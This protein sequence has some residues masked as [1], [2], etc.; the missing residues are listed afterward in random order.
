MALVP[1]F[2]SRARSRGAVASSGAGGEAFEAVAGFT[3]AADSINASLMQRR[4]AIF[5]RDA[6]EA[7][8][9][10]GRQG[11]PELQ[12]DVSAQAEAFNAAALETYSVRTESDIRRKLFDAYNANKNN[13]GAVESSFEAIRKD[14][15][16]GVLPELHTGIDR[17][18]NTELLTGLEASGRIQEK[19]ILDSARASAAD[20]TADQLDSI[21][22]HSFSIADSARNAAIVSGEMEALEGILLRHGPKGEFKF[23]GKTLPDDPN[24]TGAY[25]VQDIGRILEQAQDRAAVGR[26]MGEFD[27]SE[28]LQDKMALRDDLRPAWE[29]GKLKITEGQVR[30]LENRMDADIRRSQVENNASVSKLSREIRDVNKHIEGGFQVSAQDMDGLQARVSATGNGA[31]A[32]NL[33]ALRRKATLQQR[34]RIMTPSSLELVINDIEGQIADADGVATF[35]QAENL[36][37]ARTL[38]SEMSREVKRDPLSWANR[39]GVAEVDP[40]FFQDTPTDDAPDGEPGSAINS[41]QRRQAQAEA[42]AEFYGIPPKYLTDEEA[43]QISG[44]L[45]TADVADQLDMVE[46]INAGFGEEASK[47]VLARLSSDNPMFA[48]AGGIMADGLPGSRAI[49]GEILAGVL[50]QKEGNKVSIDA[51]VAPSIF[52]DMEGGSLAFSVEAR[53]NILK[54]AENIYTTRA[55]QAGTSDVFDQDIWEASL[56]AAVGGVIID[57]EKFGG[58]GDFNGE[59]AVLPTGFSQDAFDDIFD[60]DMGPWLLNE[61]VRHG[62]GTALTADEFEDARLLNVGE[63]LYM[64]DLSEDGTR[65]MSG[66]LPGQPFILDARQLSEDPRP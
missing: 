39:V 28:K 22:R 48:H 55:L 51:I 12:R 19:R 49:A 46:R 13:P 11:K 17:L 53:G 43:A 63:G 60:R 59:A 8:A 42:V 24:R 66:V 41:M 57:G 32:E 35:E 62:D 64:I 33:D 10:A 52:A 37:M 20:V 26:V 38:Q 58:F 40:I 1:T 23:N 34:L 21:E 16:K 36:G 30:A 2:K 14:A 29:A 3:D 18:I 6:K 27:R 5:I 7:G 47:A 9:R 25:S 44:L 15:K 50:A 65:I 61:G 45:P 54:A 31:L 4:D 56:D